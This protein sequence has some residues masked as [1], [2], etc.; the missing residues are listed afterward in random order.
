MVK[1]E[2]PKYHILLVDA[3]SLRR[4]ATAF[5]C[6]DS[7][8]V[9]SQANSGEQAFLMIDE[10]RDEYDL[11]IVDLEMPQMSALK[12]V[13]ALKKSRPRIPVF[14]VSAFQDKLRFMELLN[15]DDKSVSEKLSVC[16][17]NAGD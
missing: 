1:E 7:G 13:N 11:V 16:K 6:E 9:I 5:L 14:I 8:F 17:I 10:G 3:D 15:N 2:S 12:L 4:T